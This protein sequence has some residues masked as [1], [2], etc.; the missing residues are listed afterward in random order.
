MDNLT[1]FVKA[2]LDEEAAAAEKVYGHWRADDSGN[3]IDTSYAAYLAIGPNG[4]GID[5]ATRSHILRYDPARVL[6]EVAAKRAIVA[7]YEASVRGVG[8]GLSGQPAQA[9][10]RR[11]RRLE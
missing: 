8:E 2:R 9:R 3:L 11:C 7:D 4:K 5:E 10:S 1:G 6:R